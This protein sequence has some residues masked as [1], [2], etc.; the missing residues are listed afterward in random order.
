MKLLLIGI[1]TTM[2]VVTAAGCSSSSSAPATKDEVK[3]FHADA[4]KMPADARAK[5][6]G[7]QNTRPSGVPR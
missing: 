6:Q 5:M 3:A 2:I 4:S 7:A 1:I